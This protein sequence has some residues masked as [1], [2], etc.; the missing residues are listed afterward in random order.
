MVP[1][2]KGQYA[3][4]IGEPCEGKCLERVRIKRRDRFVSKWRQI[5]GEMRSR[6]TS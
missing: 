3:M 5:K 2:P 1:V 6:E 4:Q